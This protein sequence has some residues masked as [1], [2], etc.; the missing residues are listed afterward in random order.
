MNFF[1][2]LGKTQSWGS[3]Q[4]PQASIWNRSRGST[5]DN[6]ETEKG[7]YVEARLLGIAPRYQCDWVIGD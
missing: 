6:K 7:R 1:F 3:P 4:W 2:L 5:G